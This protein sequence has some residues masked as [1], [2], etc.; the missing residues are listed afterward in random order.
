MAIVTFMSDFG[1]EDHYVAAV[2]GGLLNALPEALI[3]QTQ[4]IDISH[5]IKHHDIGHAA[6]VLSQSYPHFPSGTIHL[7]G[8]EAADHSKCKTLICL[9]D[10][11]IFV[12]ADTG[13]FC[14]INPAASLEIFELDLPYHPFAALAS[15]VPVVASLLAGKSAD[16]LANRTTTYL[17]LFPRQA[18]VTKRE[19][20]GNVIRVDTYGNLITNIKQED[21]HK[22]LQLNGDKS[23]EVQM[24]R[25]TFRSFHLAYDDVESGECYLLFNSAG[26]L[27]F[28][29]NKGNGAQLLGIRFDAPIYISFES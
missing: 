20:V 15:Y 21:F 3:H 11:H 26:L 10:D 18:K 1:L 25:N 6:Y 2:K 28:G 9:L 13:L 5:Q 14:L 17:Q 12:G 22:M 7:V 4:I 8:I 16:Q 24:G 27:Q 29:L 19:I 23:Y